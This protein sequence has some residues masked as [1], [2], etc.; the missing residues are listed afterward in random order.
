MTN[1]G[2]LI[3][4]PP[5]FVDR[6]RG[7]FYGQAIGDALGLGT[8]FLTRDLVQ[9]CYPYRL[10]RYGQ[11]LRDAHRSRWQSGAWTD[12]TDQ[13][14][15]ILDSLLAERRVDILDIAAR[16]RQWADHGGMGIGNTVYQVLYSPDFLADPHAAAR[17]VWERSGRYAAANG[18]VMRTAVLGVWQ[19]QDAAQ[20]RHNAEQVCKITHYDP[21][22]AA[23][24]VIVCVLIAALLRGETDIISL[25]PDAYAIARAYDARVVEYLDRA[26]QPTLDALD[27]DEGLDPE[28]GEW[29]SIGYTLKTLGAGV[30]A[31]QHA[32]S[33]KAGLLAVIHE[34]GDADSNGAVAG[35]LLGARFGFA[36]LPPK[37]VAGLKGKEQLDARITQLLDL[38]ASPI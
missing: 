20:V 24:C 28:A 10:T 9:R 16:F 14:L 31:L 25:L 30:W 4:R 5:Q 3:T 37:L 8:E 12:D 7:V 23:S 32:E 34:G 33:Y 6:L 18:G 29:G 26:S 27:L 19:Y 38:L 15:C 2:P 13:M 22:C 17:Q 21:R 1:N 36:Q 11:I 35:A